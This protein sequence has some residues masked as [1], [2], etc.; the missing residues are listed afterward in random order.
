MA[1]FRSTASGPKHYSARYCAAIPL[2]PTAHGQSRARPRHRYVLKF[3]SNTS[4]ALAG[5]AAP[6]L[7]RCV[8]PKLRPIGP[9]GNPWL[10]R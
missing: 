5:N 4:D 6:P 10:V 3:S 7:A 2:H 1:A 8:N 9:L